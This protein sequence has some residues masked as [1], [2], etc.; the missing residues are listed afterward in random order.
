MAMLDYFSKHRDFDFFVVTVEHGI[1]GDASVADSEFVLAQ[2]RARGVAARCVHVDVPAEKARCGGTLEEVAR[3]LRYGVFE[4]LVSS[5]EADAVVLAHNSDDQTETVL[6]RLLR[7][8]GLRGLTGMPVV[9]G[10]VYLRPLLGVSRAEI[11][12]YVAENGVEYRD[13]LTNGDQAY[14]RNFLR[15][16]VLPLLKT[17][18][19][20]A[21][22]SVLRLSRR[23]KEAVELIS[24]LAPDWKFGDGKA[25]FDLPFSEPLPAKYA[26]QNAMTALGATRDVEEV[27]LEALLKLA[28]GENGKRLDLPFGISAHVEYGKLV[29][30]VAAPETRVEIPFAEAVD[31][32]FSSSLGEVVLRFGEKRF[33]PPSVLSLNAD[34][35]PADTVLRNRKEGDRFTKFGGGTTSLSDYLIDK[36]IPARLRDGLL[37]LAAG[38]EVFAIAG[39]EI[40]DTVRVSPDT[41]R[42]LAV[43]VK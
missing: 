14:S 40:S 4:E 8:T 29:L 16:S 27:H 17:R 39:V 5:G 2:C 35:L 24:S 23:A 32:S 42:V 10:G 7:G 38:S 3:T 25:V 34:A 28:Q 37:L 18:Y 33:A 1:R 15:N 43:I 31:G 19:P 21:D 20:E 26:L 41:S 6:L 36:K 11:D 12:E 22:K 13:D 30:S 9:R